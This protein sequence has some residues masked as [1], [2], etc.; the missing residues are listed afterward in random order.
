MFQCVAVAPMRSV[1]FVALISLSAA[2]GFT[3]IRCGQ[4]ATP[5]F[6]ARSSSVPPA[7]T[8]A[9]PPK[10]PRSCTASLTEVTL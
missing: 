7:Y 8:A 4:R 3:S 1:S 6:I 9:S 2:I 10:S 5:S